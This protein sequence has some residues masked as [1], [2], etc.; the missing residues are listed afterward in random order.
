MD[1]KHI[2]G[3][4]NIVANGLSLQREQE[5]CLVEQLVESY[6]NKLFAIYCLL[7]TEEIDAEVAVLRDS[8]HYVIIRE[9]LYWYMCRR[10]VK[11]P[12]IEEHCHILCEVHDGAGHY[13]I[14][15]TAEHLREK[16]WWP[17][18]FEYVKT[19]LKEYN[20][21][22]MFSKKHLVTKPINP[23]TVSGLFNM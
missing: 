6:E 1:I 15:S 9:V 19:Y 8:C 16:Y 10:L 20:P 5:I 4:K 2:P 17:N 23:I 18:Y 13:G 7:T 22:Q 14:L 21:C 11:V 12:K 3:K